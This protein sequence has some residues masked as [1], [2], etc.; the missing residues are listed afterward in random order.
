MI[1]RCKLCG[2]KIRGKNHDKGRHHLDRVE[3]MSPKEIAHRLAKK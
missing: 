3:K 1:K 2:F